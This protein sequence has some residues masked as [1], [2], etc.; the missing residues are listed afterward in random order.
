MADT[1][2]T[3]GATRVRASWLNDVNALT[4]NAPSTTDSTKGAKLVGWFRSITGFVGRT[5]S[6]KL[7]DRY[8]ANDM[9]MV[10][11]KTVDETTKITDLLSANNTRDEID[12]DGK[13]PRVVTFSNPYGKRFKNGIIVKNDTLRTGRYNLIN[14]TDSKL[15][16]VIGREYLFRQHYRHF[17]GGTNTIHIYGNSVLATAGANGG[18][19]PTE[20]EAQKIIKR[21]LQEKGIRSQINIINH[22]ISGSGWLGTN[23]FNI[24]S[25]LGAPGGNLGV[26]ADLT[27]AA[28]AIDT[29]IVG[30]GHNDVYLGAQGYIDTMRSQLTAVRA[31][32][33]GAA[34]SLAIVLLVPGAMFDPAN[35]RTIEWQ[36]QLYDG[37]IQIAREFQCCLIN[38]AGEWNDAWGPNYAWDN[39]YGNGATVHPLRET[40]N[41]MMMRVANTLMT[42][43]EANIYY[44]SDPINMTLNNGWVVDSV[45]NDAR[46]SCSKD[47][48][49]TISLDIK[50]GTTAAF[51]TIA[52][53][54]D[55]TMIPL[56]IEAFTAQ[57]NG[58]LVG[59]FVNS[60]VVLI[61]GSGTANTFIKGTFTYKRSMV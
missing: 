17:A 9:A 52:T 50:S 2:F 61:S 14:T 6:D 8:T 35:F 38:I 20:F 43:D 44:P 56:K 16:D 18:L 59:I 58:G 34:S 19:V 13:A 37:Y 45:A 31:H 54:P 11:D 57:T 30:Y 53:I 26:M 49:V 25:S 39:P 41:M 36:E 51:T 24:A 7:A 10:G 12:L 46:I 21:A 5:V 33:N 3:D 4:Y 28:G 55:T 47:G 42:A 48:V 29:I 15:K 23:G 32:P 22:A 60:N 40:H 1:N 27:A